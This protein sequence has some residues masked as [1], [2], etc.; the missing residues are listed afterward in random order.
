[1]LIK[2]KSFKNFIESIG[3]GCKMIFAETQN[4]QIHVWCKANSQNDIIF[5]IILDESKCVEL[6]NSYNIYKKEE[7]TK[8]YQNYLNNLKKL[9]LDYS[10]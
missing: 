10:L 8:A 7:V 5:K 2:T 6:I 3:K 9:K 1:M 4:N